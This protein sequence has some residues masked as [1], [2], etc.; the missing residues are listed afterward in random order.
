[1]VLT[2]K[3]NK[4]VNA[5]FYQERLDSLLETKNIQLEKLIQ[6]HA[7]E[8]LEHRKGFYKSVDLNYASR[9]Y[10]TTDTLSTMILH[11]EV[12]K[13]LKNG[14]LLK[15]SQHGINEQ[16]QEKIGTMEDVA[17]AIKRKLAINDDEPIIGRD[18]LY[19]SF[20]FYS[21]RLFIL[22]IFIIII[23]IFCRDSIMPNLANLKN[24]KK[25][26]FEIS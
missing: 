20:S 10:S 18:E 12:E 13:I 17:D 8:I 25:K 11:P 9:K 5:E 15:P 3:L 26:N 14:S 16:K 24:A 23:I 4:E 21:K 22:N 7:N 19:V 2:N 6:I 1:M